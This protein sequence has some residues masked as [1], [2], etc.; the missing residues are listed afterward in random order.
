MLFSKSLK[1]P[2]P[3]CGGVSLPSKK[4]CTS[5]L[6]PFFCKIPQT[7]S[8]CFWWEWTPP[9]DISPIK[10]QVPFVSLSLLISSTSVGFFS[11]L[12]SLIARSIFGK[13]CITTRPA[14]RFVC[15]TSEFPICPS[16]SP[17]SYPDVSTKQCGQVASRLCQLG[18]CPCSMALSGVT[19]ARYPQPSRINSITGFCIIFTPYLIYFISNR[20]YRSL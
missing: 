11:R 12:P 16:G 15:P 17:T 20:I 1:K 7:A 13:S 4:A 9:G 2:L 14:P 8:I 19:F 3:D 10:W 5:T 6:M 18:V